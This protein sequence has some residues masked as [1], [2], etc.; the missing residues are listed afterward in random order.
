MMLR[1]WP[2]T[3]VS[4]RQVTQR[5]AGRETAG[6]DG[7]VALTA[8]ARMPLAVRVHRSIGSRDPLPVKRVYVPKANAKLRPLGVPAIMDRCHQ[9]RAKNA[10]E[11]EWE[12]RFGPRS[13]GFRPGRS[14]QDA[15]EAI[16]D[17]CK[18]RGAARVWTLDAD[19][20]AASGTL[21]H[22][23][24]MSAVGSFPGRGMIRAWLTAGVFEPGKGFAPTA[25]GSP[26]GGV[27]SPLLLNV[28]LHGLEEAAGV[29]YGPGGIRIAT[30]SP[31]LVRYCD[32]FV[33][34][35]HT[36]QQAEQV[37]ARLAGWLA[38]PGL[39]FNDEKT[40]IVSLEAGYDFLGFNIRRYRNGK[41]LIK[42]GKVAVRRVKHKLAGQM[43]RLRGHNASAVLA[44][45]CP[46]TRCWASYY[47]SVVS[48]Q[49]F[50]DVDDYLWKLTY[51]W[52]CRSHPG[53]PRHWITRRYFGQFNPSRNNNRVFGDAAN[54]ACLPRLAWT[55]SSGTARSPAEPHP[56]TL[57][58]P[59]AGTSGAAGTSP[60]PTAAPCACSRCSTDAA[61]SA[62]TCSC[63]PTGSRILPRNGNGG[64]A[65][66]AK[67]SPGNSSHAGRA[68]RMRPA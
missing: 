44:A 52:A 9:A 10:L 63:T 55:P 24:L 60:R 41:L 45:I 3:L 25:E 46:I 7:E 6:V 62:R 61:R 22:S 29:R 23:H 8:P 5:N 66:P 49:T 2:D 28:A 33:V 51:K 54:G 4:V 15:I 64:T 57:P 27:I 13:Y 17:T 12:A 21:D 43:R 58:W 36:R 18:G 65:P 34:C 40:K 68:R 20:A 19:L 11:P 32:D 37:R 38:P 26:Q 30:G 16:Y 42:P 59:P 39:A 1:S 53:K 31:V 48:K 67:R 14:C 56:T 50:T 47:R 35:C